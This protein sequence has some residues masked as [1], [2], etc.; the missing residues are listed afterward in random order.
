MKKI[1]V[2]ICNYNG[3]EY[4]INCIKSLQDQS[5]QNFDV[6][7]VDNASTDG[8]VENINRTFGNFVTILQNAE[9]LGGA[10]G[11]DRG[12]RYG[13]DHNYEFIA[14][15]DNDVVLDKYA[16]ENMYDYLINHDDTGIVGA[17]ILKMDNPD[18]MMDFGSMIDFKNYDIIMGYYGHKDSND[19]PEM[20]E[21]DYVPACAAMTRRDVL[22]KCGTMPA[23]CF[24]Y[25]DDVE[26]CYKM[27]LKGYK[28][29]AY[30]KAKAWHK[31]S[32]GG[33]ASTFGRY[34]RNRNRYNFFAKYIPEDDINNFAD[35]II[36]E[37][38]PTLYGSHYKKLDGIFETTWYIFYDFI[39]NIRG[40]AK[41][42][43]IHTI[44]RPDP[45]FKKAINNKKS[46]LISLADNYDDNSSAYIDLYKIIKR[47]KESNIDAK[48]YVSLSSWQ[49]DKETFINK[50]QNVCMKFRKDI[51]SFFNIYDKDTCEEFD[52]K[53]ELCK[54]VTLVSKNI[55]PVVYVDKYFNCITNDDD[56]KYYTNY[57]NCLNFFKHIY[58]NQINDA[59]NNIRKEK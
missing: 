1:G 11:F 17:K 18:E 30:G 44:I 2:F 22:L 27:T 32:S 38:F 56:F 15:L 10:G 37:I 47:I 53:I 33:G 3:G 31:G 50:M 9:N 4:T 29:A 6:Y 59:I 55:L 52:M 8:S 45:P 35:T 42:N 28:V 54:H 41:E 51:T 46:I 49:D 7:V 36:N 21:C 48:I 24:I 43:R 26:F 12:L 20:I 23:D 5:I 19:I 25:F 14:I 16:I 13:I 40:K 58:K 34:Y 57:E 39:N